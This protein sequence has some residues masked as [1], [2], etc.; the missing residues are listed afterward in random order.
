MLTS[1]SIAKN[2]RLFRTKSLDSLNYNLQNKKAEF[3]I[4]PLVFKFNES[5]SKNC[6]ICLSDSQIFYNYC[7]LCKTPIC[8]DCSNI[9]FKNNIRCPTCKDFWTSMNMVA[10]NIIVYSLLILSKFSLCCSYCFEDFSEASEKKTISG[11]IKKT[12]SGTIK[13]TISGAIKKTISAEIIEHIEFCKKLKKCNDCLKFINKKKYLKHVKTC[14]KRKIMCNNCNTYISEY[15]IEIHKKSCNISRCSICKNYNNMVVCKLCNNFTCKIDGYLC[16]TCQ[17]HICPD[18]IAKCDCGKKDCQ[19]YCNDVYCQECIDRCSSCK[20]YIL[21]SKKC[22]ICELTT[23][24]KCGPCVHIHY[25]KSYRSK[26]GIRCNNCDIKCYVCN[27]ICCLECCNIC[28][29]CNKIAFCDNCRNSYNDRQDLCAKCNECPKC[30]G[31]VRLCL[32]ENRTCCLKC[33]ENCKYCIDNTCH[34]CKNIFNRR[35]LKKCVDCE[36][37]CCKSCYLIDDIGLTH[38]QWHN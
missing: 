31:K 37:L 36:S 30:T 2:S 14:T 29:N 35:Q 34:L 15:L 25:C 21:H 7:E 33:E 17:S 24:E 3:Y 8:T 38:C 12:I 5:L 9:W 20:K 13:K 10:F 11:T 19:K 32:N 18:C 6:V 4:N 1:K 22:P 16:Q 28:K 23:C 26:L 27:K